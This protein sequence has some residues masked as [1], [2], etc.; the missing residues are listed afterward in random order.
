MLKSKEVE[1]LSLQDF[2]VK[3]LPY[4]FTAEWFNGNYHLVTDA[5]YRFPVDQPSRKDDRCKTHSRSC[6]ENPNC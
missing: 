1:N 3:M 4:S 2:T 5:V 6:S